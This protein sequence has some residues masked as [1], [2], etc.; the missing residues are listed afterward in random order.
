M[1]YETETVGTVE[2]WEAQ[3][4]KLKDDVVRAAIRFDEQVITSMGNPHRDRLHQRIEA[5]FAHNYEHPKGGA[6]DR[7]AEDRKAGR[8]AS[9]LLYDAIFDEGAPEPLTFAH[10][11]ATNL[12][13]SL[14]WHKGGLEE[15][16]VSDWACAMAGEAGEVCNA[17]K[18][19]NR[20]D[21]DVQQNVGPQTREQAIAAI[22]TEIGDTFMYLDLLAQR[23]GIDT[24][25][26]VRDTFNRISEREGFPQRL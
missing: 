6:G 5:L 3:R 17:V 11:S 15:W 1:S 23:L 19:L 20:I 14:L 16:S 22:A 18:K 25:Q 10:V 4:S 26:A 21:K 12:E 2:D 13:R 8:S 7:A 9:E 24:A